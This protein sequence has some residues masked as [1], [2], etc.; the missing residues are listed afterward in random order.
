MGVSKHSEG[1]GEELGERRG[2]EGACEGD[3]QGTVEITFFFP[4][5]CYFHGKSSRKVSNPRGPSPARLACAVGLWIKLYSFGLR[6]CL[7]LD[8][9]GGRRVQIADSA[10]FGHCTLEFLLERGCIDFCASCASRPGSLPPGVGF[11]NLWG[12]AF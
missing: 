4:P 1:E 7:F 2:V 5:R 10:R 9:K 11:G 12:Q 8:L 6:I 3:G